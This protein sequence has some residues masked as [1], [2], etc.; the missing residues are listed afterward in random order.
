V[1]L[2][3]LILATAFGGSLGTIGAVLLWV[4]VGRFLYRTWLEVD[5]IRDRLLEVQSREIAELRRKVA[6][7]EKERR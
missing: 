7:L 1:E 5:S 2:S 3:T 4:L 6:E